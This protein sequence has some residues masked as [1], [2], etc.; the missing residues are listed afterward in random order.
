MQFSNSKARYLI[1]LAQAAVEGKLVK[2]ELQLL[3]ISEASDHL[4]KLKGVGPWS[5]HYAIMKCLRFPSAFPIADVGLHNA[6]KNQLNLAEKP[7]IE[8]IQELATNWK[9][10]ESY[11]TFYLWHSLIMD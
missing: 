4:C 8:Q 5:A 1:N 11:A 10:W 9:G 2:Q 3:S 7:S 6:I